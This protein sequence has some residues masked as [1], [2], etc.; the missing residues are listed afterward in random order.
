MTVK[1][2]GSCVHPGGGG[3]GGGGGGSAV[4]VIVAGPFCPSLV[5]V[6]VTEPARRPLTNPL[7]LTVATRVLV[8]AHVTVR[9][10]STLPP[11]S[12]SV[13]VNCCVP[14]TPILALAGLTATVA[15]G[16]VLAD[17]V[18]FPTFDTP[19]N[20]ASTFSVPRNATSWN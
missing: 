15:T 17:V 18:A 16:A 10:V 20:T 4:T 9:P 2:L 7:P 1:P 19:P 5:A 13:A 11:A 12:R 8:L 14:A 3:G 6:I